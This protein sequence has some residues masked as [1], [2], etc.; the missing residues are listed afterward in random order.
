MK[1]MNNMRIEPI[2]NQYL[3]RKWMQVTQIWIRRKN[4]ALL[5]LFETIPTVC[6]NNYSRNPD[7]IA[8]HTKINHPFQKPVMQM[9]KSTMC[10]KQ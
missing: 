4:I 7:K 9:S 10:M 5:L 1:S 2:P 6:A 3:T 8:A